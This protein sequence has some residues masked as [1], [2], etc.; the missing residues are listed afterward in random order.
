[1]GIPA[2][3]AYHVFSLRN[4][5]QSKQQLW[6]KLLA[7][8]VGTGTL[9]LSATIFTIVI[10]TNISP[11]LNAQTERNAIYLS[12]SGYLFQALIEGVFTLMLISFLLKVKPEL[13]KQ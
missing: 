1:M 11:D 13:L 8:C 10:I 12:L 2:L 3:L 4:R 7:F 6:T 5:F 9:G